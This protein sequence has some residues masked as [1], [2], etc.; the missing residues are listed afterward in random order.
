MRRIQFTLFGLSLCVLCASVATAQDSH[1]WTLQYG[2]ES[3]LLGGLVIGSVSD[4]SATYY[5]PGALSRARDLS[6]A[7]S[8]NVFEVSGILLEDG[9]GEG[10]NLGRQTSGLRPSMVAGTIADSAFGGRGVIGYSAM[11]RVKGGQDFSGFLGREADRLDP[12][13]ELSDLF[14]LVRFEGQYSDFWGGL[15]YS[16]RIGNGFGI[17]V[18]GYI[19]SRSQTRRRED[20]VEAISLGGDGSASINIVGGNYSTLRAIGKLG[21]YWTA[22]D[23][24]A[25]LTVTTPS[26]HITGSGELGFNEATVGPDTVALAYA[27]Q[28]GLPSEYRT[29]LSVGGGIGIPIG[30]LKIHAS[31][32][33]F[34]KLDLY[35]A[36]QG[37]TVTAKEPEDREIPVEAGSGGGRGVQ[38]GCRRRI[39]YQQAFRGVCFILPG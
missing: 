13:L 25:G 30:P 16:H 7:I 14:A 6:F 4:V 24:S 32:E 9:G 10:V 3:S 17:G 18:T 35:T 12:E 19:A 33:W 8:T 29:P 34:D 23:M 21:L 26:A 36:I 1:Y 39:P 31:A 5:N 38:L 22:G 37:E 15:T 20:L 28:T 2:P 27:I 11:N